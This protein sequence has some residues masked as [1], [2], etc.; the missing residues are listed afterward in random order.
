M[1]WCCKRKDFRWWKMCFV[2]IVP[3]YVRQ[4]TTCVTV[5]IKLFTDLNIFLAHVIIFGMTFL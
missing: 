5:S 3:H 2:E 1:C 4:R